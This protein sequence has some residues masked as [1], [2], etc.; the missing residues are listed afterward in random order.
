MDKDTQAARKAR[1]ERLRRQISRIIS[2]PDSA[3]GQ[4]ETASSPA[5]TPEGQS[6]RSQ[7]ARESPRDFIHRRM[8]EL[9]GKRK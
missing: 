7:P 1:A 8:R 9:K 4:D 2:E 6:P 3:Q 5:A